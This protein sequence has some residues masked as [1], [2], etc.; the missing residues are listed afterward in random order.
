MT[1]LIQAAAFD[2]DRLE[3]FAAAEME[4]AV[5]ASR[6]IVPGSLRVDLVPSGAA[7]DSIYEVRDGTFPA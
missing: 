4:E 1:A 7:G 5:G 6:A 2:S 3:D